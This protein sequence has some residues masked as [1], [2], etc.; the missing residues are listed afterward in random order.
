M[1]AIKRFVAIAALSLA[2]A[3]ANAAPNAIQLMPQQ[4]SEFQAAGHHGGWVDNTR[5]A[6]PGDYNN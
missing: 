5:A 3:L 4:S 1:N 2:P 6:T